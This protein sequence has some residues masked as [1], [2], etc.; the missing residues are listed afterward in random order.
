[1][2]EMADLRENTGAAFKASYAAL[3][4]AQ[5]EAVD[6][7]EGPVMV[8]AGPGTGKTTVLTLR[9][10]NILR[11]TD[12]PP[13]GILAITYTDAGVKAMKAKL[14]GLI[15]SR[16]HEVRVHTF[17]SFAKSVIDGYPDH[18]LRIN[19]FRQITDIE[20]ESIIRQIIAVP[21]YA[22]LRP[23]GRP[24]TYLSAMLR[25]ISDAKREALSPAEVA[26]FAQAEIDRL[27]ADESSV[28][29]RGAS[30]GQLKAAALEQ[31]KKCER[32]ILFSR[33]YAAYEEKKQELKLLDFDDLIIE[34][35]AALQNDE[36]LRRLVQEQFLYILV[37]EHQDTND[38]QNLIIRLLA[39]FFETPNV[40]IVGDEKQA[41]YRFQ[42]ASVEN[43][44]KLQKL[45]PGM[46][47]ISL[48]TNYRSHQSIL[49]ASFSMI[50][51]NY[52]GDEHQ[53]L[54]IHLSAGRE[55]KPR[56]IE[57][58]TGDNTIAIE[59][60]LIKSIRE[61]IDQESAATIAV[62]TRR[63]FELERVLAALESNGISVSSERSVDIFAHPIGKAV[64]DLLE[65][66]SD[67]TRT[68][69]LARTMVAGLWDL[70]LGRTGDLLAQLKSGRIASLD[71]HLPALKQLAAARLTDDP[72][73][74]L[75]R[76]CEGAGLNTLIARHPTSAQV[77]RGIITLA[78]S[79]VR[80]QHL[81]DPADLMNA[82]LSYRRSAESRTVKVSV[83]APDSAVMA[84][85][86]HGSKGLEFD[87]VFL[88]YA[89][90]EAWIGRARG[91]SFV[92]PM[93][94]ED[95]DEVQDLR[96]LF[97]V[98]LT[99]ARRHAVILTALEEQDGKAQ[100]PL[101]FIDE[102]APEHAA[103][104][105]LPRAE[106]PLPKE[107][108]SGSENAS[109]TAITNLAKQKLLTSGLSV[110]ALNH[111]LESPERFLYDSVLSMPQALNANAEKGR[112][113]H[114]AMDRVWHA[115][116]RSTANIE[117]II[118][119]AV[120]DYLAGS[121]LEKGEKEM[122][123]Q[124]LLADA[125]AVAESL[126]G[127]FNT[128]TTVLT[129]HWIETDLELDLNGETITI[130]IH[131]ILDAIMEKSGEVEV[132]DYK[133]KQPMSEA[134]I[135]GETQ[136]SDGNYFRQLV[137]YT[138]LLEKSAR[139]AGRRT[140]AALVFVSPDKKGRCAIRNI[141][142]TPEDIAKI[143]EDISSLVKFVWS[144]ELGKLV[145]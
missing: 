3:N 46:K 101:R 91:K 139:F 8:I 36:L 60:Y 97:Y 121:L 120:N 1:M 23:L 117:T 71:E 70:S 86:A 77:W 131:G 25:T 35:L 40:F 140:S 107:A 57:I 81:A 51:H 115:E 7:I 106:L 12:T 137:F 113:M 130:P 52:A 13:S 116:G 73:S 69:A 56:P 138:L 50:E 89:T 41:I 85:T 27:R 118:K 134:A 5:R 93:G 9:I 114:A 109:A 10:A 119:E 83:G 84:M 79:L 74:F 128:E 90:E 2:M 38:A 126:A 141:A 58:V 95:G 68:D 123:R 145:E 49:D 18:F 104:T 111:F 67:P 64:F 80:G 136:S 48:D 22:E 72:L 127:H 108:G 78:E 21:E 88:P 94:R 20:K 132:F 133:T 11:Q 143:K 66:L 105:R 24:D 29:T 19:D 92:L 96:R 47:L 63:N 100:V 144:G 15:G 17:H 54:R 122:V 42:G 65:Y 129:E 76:V 45:W 6:T 98:A 33:V 102:I 37:D 61:I 39:E 82:L 142:I 75:I 26:A 28:S 44:L 62:I 16:A 30:K 99:R 124:K 59:Q 112:A 31:I 55:E 4:A 53:D 34:L 87:Y 110:T 135:R 32:T 103:A 14:S 43:F 125:P